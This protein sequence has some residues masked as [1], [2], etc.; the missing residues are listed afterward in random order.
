MGLK[1]LRVRPLLAGLFAASLGLVS[2][3]AQEAMVVIPPT[4]QARDAWQALEEGRFT[5]AVPL[6]THAL[7]ATPGH[8]TLLLGAGLVQRRLGNVEGARGALTRALQTEPAL[9][10]ASLLLGMMLYEQ[11]DVHGA[12][13]VYESA[14]FRAPGHAQLTAHLE[15]WRREADAQA[16]FLR[17]D[18][19]R[20]TVLFEGP[21][22]EAL[23]QAAL[24]ILDDAYARVG[25]ALFVYPAEPVQVV[26]YTAE[27]FRD[28]ARSP[29]WAGGL[30]DGRIKLPVRGALQNREEF[31]RVLTH[32]YVHAVVRRMAASGVPAWLNEGLAVYLERP[33]PPRGRPDPRVSRGTGPVAALPTSFAALP[34][35]AVKGA[36]EASGAAVAAMVDRVGMAAVAALITDVGRGARFEQA[37][38]SHILMSFDEFA[39]EFA[40]RR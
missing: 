8:P 10:P 1:G 36:Y 9:T 15:R 6:F 31:A 5:D 2:A 39:R 14:L 16:G 23:A 12:I 34:A 33:T 24:D 25:D 18:G 22:E 38:A 21:A 7:R 19:G 11:G 40:E 13:K 28:V 30:Y 29:E 20:F 3:L 37:F 17:A 35:P 4:P 27:Q 32:E 26:L